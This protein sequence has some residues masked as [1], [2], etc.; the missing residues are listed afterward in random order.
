MSQFPGSGDALRYHNFCKQYYANLRPCDR[1]R[2]GAS[3]ILL[4]QEKPL[5]VNFNKVSNMQLISY[6]E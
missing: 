2:Y 1:G 4:F 6:V 5:V 3:F